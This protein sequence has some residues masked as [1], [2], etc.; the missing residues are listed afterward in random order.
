MRIYNSH[1]TITRDTKSCLTKDTL[2]YGVAN[3]N[4][5]LVAYADVMMFNNAN[6]DVQ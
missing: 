5:C 3:T 6:N 2:A 1:E 4:N